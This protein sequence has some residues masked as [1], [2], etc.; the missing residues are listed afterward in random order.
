MSNDSKEPSV[1]WQTSFGGLGETLFGIAILAVMLGFLC[2]LI[3]AMLPDSIRYP[4][5]YS[6]EYTVNSKQVHVEKMPEDCD[7]SHAPL[8]S[9]GCHYEK[10]I[11]PVTNRAG[12][13]TDVFVTW[14]KVPD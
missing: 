13:V 10:R 7:F 8:G 4:M 6:F 3:W 14:D 5:L 12:A 1:R 9:K 2:F 11:S